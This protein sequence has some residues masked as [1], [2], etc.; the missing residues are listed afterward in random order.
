MEELYDEYKALLFT[1]AY[2]LTGSVTDAEDVV[3]DVF[4][5]AYEVHVE[6]LEEP[7]A[8]LCKM[9][10]NH[11]LN[12]Q[13]SARKRRE[14]YVGPWL[15]EPIRT[16]EEDTIET[17]V[18]HRDLLSYAMLVLLERLTPTERA[19][20][21]LREA[22]SFD[23]TEIAEL[24]DKREANCRKLMSRAKSKL[25]LSEEETVA[26]EAGELEWVSRFLTS[27]EQGNLDLIMSLLTEDV[28]LV[29]DGGG[30]VKALKRSIQTRDHVARVLLIGIGKIAANYQE[31]LHLDV[32]PLNGE[33]SIVL[34]S[35]DEPIAAI[36][37]QLRG[38]KFARIYIVQNPDK[39]TR[40]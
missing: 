15:P 24:L 17:T 31:N 40:V 20:F 7:K 33:T 11:C 18:V 14:I 36:F 13:K 4:F 16:P 10:T 21:V 5:K 27:L 8:Y 26:N 39:L 38:G 25:G 23:Y 35:G 12:L 3:Q 22:L 9:V 19:V 2:Q 29:S 1:L 34:R 37:V 6:R 30:K 28:L 32:T